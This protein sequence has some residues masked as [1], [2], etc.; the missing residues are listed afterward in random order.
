MEIEW[1]GEGVDTVGTDRKTGK[2]IIKINPKYFRP[3]EVDLLVGDSSKAKEK[4][5]WI[6]KTSFAELVEVMAVADQKR[7]GDGQ[8][9]F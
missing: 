6:S 4:L 1:S 8:V 5:G 9:N 2:A 3:A 7:V